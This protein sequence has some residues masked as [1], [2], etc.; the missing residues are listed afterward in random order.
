MARLYV[1]PDTKLHRTLLIAPMGAKGSGLRAADV[2]ASG[3][4]IS[5]LLRDDTSMSPAS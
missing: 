1:R 3:F 4:G 5:G 2:L